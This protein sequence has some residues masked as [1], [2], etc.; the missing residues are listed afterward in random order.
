ML[1]IMTRISS[2]SSSFFFYYSPFSSKTFCK[3]A[4][5][6]TKDA[7]SR[8][9]HA[10]E[11]AIHQN[12]ESE[13]KREAEVKKGRIEPRKKGAKNKTRVQ[14]PLKE[15]GRQESLEEY[16]KYYIQVRVQMY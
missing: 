2:A 6:S 15:E 5:Q 12:I 7:V 4:W 13:E 1:A 10:T 3:G 9:I 8:S 14:M 11:S 16:I